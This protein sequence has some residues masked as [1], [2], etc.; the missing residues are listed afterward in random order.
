MIGELNRLDDVM[1][2]MSLETDP[3]IKASDIGR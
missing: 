1:Q 3:G 2:R